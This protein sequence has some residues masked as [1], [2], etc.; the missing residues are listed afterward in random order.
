MEKSAAT[1]LNISNH[2]T[3]NLSVPTVKTANASNKN[4]GYL[5]GSPC[6]YCSVH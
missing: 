2:K 5:N 3:A 6:F 1:F 4:K